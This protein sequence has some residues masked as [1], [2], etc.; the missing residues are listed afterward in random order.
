MLPVSVFLYLFL[1]VYLALLLEKIED[2]FWVAGLI[3]SLLFV[4]SLLF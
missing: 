1:I 3:G 4:V 2:V